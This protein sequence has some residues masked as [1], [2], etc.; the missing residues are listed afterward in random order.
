[1][2]IKSKEGWNCMQVYTH[3]R[4]DTHMIYNS[5]YDQDCPEIVPY[6]NPSPGSSL[7]CPQ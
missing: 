1:M 3:V 7:A 5:G 4:I 6:S 2:D